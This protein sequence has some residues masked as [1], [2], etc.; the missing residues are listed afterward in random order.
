MSFCLLETSD[1]CKHSSQSQK[2]GRET[3]GTEAEK[4]FPM[5]ELDGKKK[6]HTDLTI[7]QEPKTLR[8]KL[9]RITFRQKPVADPMKYTVDLLSQ[10]FLMLP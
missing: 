10:H 7:F 8:G 9:R 2:V 5:T 4:T 6:K 3:D 1:T